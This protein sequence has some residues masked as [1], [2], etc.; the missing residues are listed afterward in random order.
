MTTTSTSTITSTTSRSARSALTRKVS[1]DSKGNILRE[2]GQHCKGCKCKG[3]CAFEETDSL[4]KTVLFAFALFLCLGCSV[5]V[6]P[7]TFGITDTQTMEIKAAVKS[8]MS[9]A[10]PALS[11]CFNSHSPS[12]DMQLKWCVMPLFA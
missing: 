2:K 3:R 9:A 1:I 8:A 7:E 4:K 12:L 5:I 6:M 10:I 11:S